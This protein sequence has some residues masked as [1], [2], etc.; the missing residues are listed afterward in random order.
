MKSHD[1][2]D[3]GRR[4]HTAT[5]VGANTYY[6]PILIYTHIIMVKEL[7]IC[8]MHF[9]YKAPLHTDHSAPREQ[10]V[11]PFSQEWQLAKCRAGSPFLLT[12][13]RYLLT[14]G[15]RDFR[16]QVIWCLVNYQAF[17]YLSLSSLLSSHN[18]AFIRDRKPHVLA[19]TAKILNLALL[20]S[21]LC[22]VGVQPQRTFILQ[23][24]IANA[25]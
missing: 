21:P 15:R 11:I 24:Q 16:S 12:S 1:E 7:I 8:T 19:Y 22:I 4:D 3:V 6:V 17:F 10:R 5:P 25:K 14:H 9:Y 23:R 13:V 20:S 18:N 2:C